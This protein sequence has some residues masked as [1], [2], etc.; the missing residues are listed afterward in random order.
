MTEAILYLL[1]LSAVL[2]LLI[3]APSRAG[4]W[5]AV[6]HFAGDHEKANMLIDKRRAER[7]AAET[8]VQV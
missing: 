1:S 5:R 4:M 7:K 3:V 2:V 6:K 8:G